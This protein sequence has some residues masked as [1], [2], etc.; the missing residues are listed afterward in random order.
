[1]SGFLSGARNAP[2]DRQGYALDGL[3]LPWAHIDSKASAV[4]SARPLM[5]QEA[6]VGG[7]CFSRVRAAPMVC[8]GTGGSAIDRARGGAK[9]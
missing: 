3:V 1:M 6:A 8:A 4:R 5:F 2:T 9:S 7:V